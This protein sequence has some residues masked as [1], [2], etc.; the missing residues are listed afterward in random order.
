MEALLMTERKAQMHL[1]SLPEQ[2]DYCG[3]RAETWPVGMYGARLALICREC[4]TV[5]AIVEAVGAS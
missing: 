3:H 4:A 1:A 2:C 5:V